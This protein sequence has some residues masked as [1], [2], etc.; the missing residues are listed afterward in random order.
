MRASSFVSARHPGREVCFS[1]EGGEGTE[2]CALNKGVSNNLT[3]TV[4]ALKQ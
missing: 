4:F 2:R 1:A 3:N